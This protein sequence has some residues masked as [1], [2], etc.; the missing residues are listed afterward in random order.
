MPHPMTIDGVGAE[1]KV[2]FRMG[3][4]CHESQRGK[5]ILTSGTGR[6]H[7]M[8][9]AGG[10]DAGVFELFIPGLKTRAASNT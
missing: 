3:P 10:G 1:G 2:F 5:E 7:Q 4:L 6:R 8:R 9:R